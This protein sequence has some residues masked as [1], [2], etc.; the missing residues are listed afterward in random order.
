MTKLDYSK[1]ART[2]GDLSHLVKIHHKVA[3]ADDHPDSP[4]ISDARERLDKI[5][6]AT[7][8]GRIN[9]CAGHRLE[10]KSP[11]WYQCVECEKFVIDP[12]YRDEQ[13]RAFVRKKTAE[14]RLA[15]IREQL[16]S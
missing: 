10:R 9:A 7:K 12:D 5:F 16:I 2:P 8:I 6:T 1:I 4:A 14:K 3:N 13:G 11:K 15:Q